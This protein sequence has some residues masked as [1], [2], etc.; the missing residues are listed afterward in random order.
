VSIG[1][2]SFK[3]QQA[4]LNLLYQF[5]KYYLELKDKEKLVLE[6]D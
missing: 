3:L 2:H 1:G 4:K 5:S 6:Y